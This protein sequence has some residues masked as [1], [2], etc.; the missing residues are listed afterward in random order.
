[1]LIIYTAAVS[2]GKMV[3]ILFQNH[4]CGPV[5]APDSWVCGWLL[6]AWQA[7]AADP[8]SP[9]FAA[10]ADKS[11]PAQE[12]GVDWDFTS[13]MSPD[14][15]SVID[16]ATLMIL[17]AHRANMLHRGLWRDVSPTDLRPSPGDFAQVQADL[18]Y[19]SNTSNTSSTRPS[20]HGACAIDALPLTEKPMKLSMLGLDSTI[21]S[22][23]LLSPV[24]RGREKLTTENLFA[25]IAVSGADAGAA[26]GGGGGGGGVGVGSGAGGQETLETL[27]SSLRQ[28]RPL[29]PSLEH[30]ALSSPVPLDVRTAHAARRGEDGT[31]PSS[32]TRTSGAPRAMRSVAAVSAVQG[33]GFSS[34]RQW[35]LK[36]KLVWI[37]SE[38]RKPRVGSGAWGGEL[39]VAWDGS[40]GCEY[41]GV[42]LYLW[43]VTPEL[44]ALVAFF[45]GL[46]YSGS[47][48]ANKLQTLLTLTSGNIVDWL[49]Y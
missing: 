33:W 11:L 32:R 12:Q 47:D 7:F 19:T 17:A 21:H 16:F 23:T 9:A 46:L 1:V 36:H 37:D 30:G 25:P 41:A 14:W 48:G 15:L 42:D 34:W 13:Y 39:E 31:H 44:F 43:V 26:G 28:R 24:S 3:A 45:I 29:R 4:F 18:Q 2:G 49:C 22:P 6:P 35:L 8:G 27:T 20:A 5:W 38:P 40:E 10:A